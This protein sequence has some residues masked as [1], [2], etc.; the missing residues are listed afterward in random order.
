M[1]K[2]SNFY[3]NENI[4]FVIIS[5]DIAKSFWWENELLGF[6]FQSVNLPMWRWIVA[7]FGYAL[8]HKFL[9]MH[10]SYFDFWNISNFYNVRSA[11]WCMNLFFP[12]ILYRGLFLHFSINV[13]A[14]ILIL[15]VLR[16]GKLFYSSNF[17]N[18]QFFCWKMRCIQSHEY[19]KAISLHVYLMGIYKKDG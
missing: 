10:F 1:W 7:S 11:P 15:I 12:P 6:D 16:I 5:C 13:T 8:I 18:I 19:M 3:E 9:L 4:I 17:S 2:K 14:Y